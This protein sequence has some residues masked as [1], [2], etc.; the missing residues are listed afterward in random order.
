MGRRVSL[1]SF[2]PWPPP[3]TQ[4]G[5]CAAGSPRHPRSRSARKGQHSQG[6]VASILRSPSFP[7]ALLG[8][9]YVLPLLIRGLSAYELWKLPGCACWS[10]QISWDPGAG[11]ITKD[12][13]PWYPCRLKN[14]KL[15]LVNFIL[16][17]QWGVVSK[18]PQDNCQWWP[19]KKFSLSISV[20]ADVFPRYVPHCRTA[21]LFPPAAH[22]GR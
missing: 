11:N 5:V 14:Q 4:P 2:L 20:T 15:Y 12:F 21:G 19:P 17:C 16:P 3:G 10:I 6:P 1:T 18:V 8:P 13:P 9:G 7:S 22:D